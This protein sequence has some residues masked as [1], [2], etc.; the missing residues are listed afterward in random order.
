MRLAPAGKDYLWGGTRLIEEYGKQLNL[1]PLAE[2]WECS[3]HPDGPSVVLSGAYAGETLDAVIRRHPELLGT[4]FRGRTELPIL[5]KFID[6][7]RDLSVQVHPDD[8]YA[9]AHEGQNGKIEF[10]YVLDAEADAQIVYGFEHAMTVR[11]LKDAIQ[12]GTFERHLQKVPVKR[13]DTFYIPAGMVH[14]IGA[15]VLLVEVQENSNVTYRL[16]DYERVDKDGHKRELHFEKAVQV[17]NMRPGSQAR[18]SSRIIRFAQGCAREMLCHCPY[19]EVERIQVKGKIDFV[20]MPES[21]Q[22]LLCVEGNVEI[23]EEMDV[24]LNMSKGMCA[25]VPAGTGHLRIHGD[26]ALLRVHC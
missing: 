3:T 15:G 1:K 9:R 11:Q 2:T 26:G 24:N 14:A 20:V 5:V 13:G 17:L 21:F 16:Y 4:K 12:K 10:W 22:V 18:R 7:H 25:F 19:F 6:A 8:A 23:G